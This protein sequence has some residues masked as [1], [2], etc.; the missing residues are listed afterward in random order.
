M[1]KQK[2]RSGRIIDILRVTNGETIKNLAVR[3]KVSEMTIRRDLNYLSEHNMVKLIHGAAII[4]PGSI[5]EDSHSEYNLMAAEDKMRSEKKRIGIQAV[6]LIED[7]DVIIVDA[8]S[9]I[10]F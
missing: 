6:S 8:G 3:L 9:S 7:D 4:N 5:F 2:E 10:F 1:S